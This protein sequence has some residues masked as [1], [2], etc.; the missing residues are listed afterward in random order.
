MLGQPV[1]HGM[2]FS[3]S[4]IKYMWFMRQHRGHGREL[5]IYLHNSSTTGR[6]HNRSAETAKCCPQYVAK[7]PRTA[8]NRW[9]D[10]ETGRCSGEDHLLLL[11]LLLCSI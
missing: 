2:T 3:L 7:V 9:T 1:G 11:L 8:L 4:R 5:V 6:S 10:V